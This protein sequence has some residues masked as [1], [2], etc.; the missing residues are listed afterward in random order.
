MSF[1]CEFCGKPQPD[2]T[3]QSKIATHRSKKYSNGG[4][5][6]E[7]VKERVACP[8]CRLLSVNPQ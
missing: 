7:I 2:G 4:V 5:G 6:K 3:K 8:K 1:K